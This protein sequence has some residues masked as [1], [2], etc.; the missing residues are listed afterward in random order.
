[1]NEH[2]NSKVPQIRFKGFSGEWVEKKPGELCDL[3]T[4]GDWIESK[5]QSAS[6]IRLLQTGNVGVNEFID[7]ADKARWISLDTFERLKCEEVFPGDILISRLPEP[8]GR[9]CIVPKL[10]HRVITAVDCT[11]VRTAKSCDPAFLVQHLSLDSYFETINNYL[12]GGTRQR[13]SRSALGEILIQI[14]KFEEQQKIGTYFRELDRLI[15]LHQRKHDKLVTLKKAML[16]KIFPQP[17]ATIPEIRFKGFS[18]GWMEIQLGNVCL[19][20][21]GKKDADEGAADGL[22]PFFTCADNHIYSHSFSFDTEAILIAGNANVGQTKYYQGKFEAYQRTYVLTDFSDINTRY[23]YTILDAKLQESLQKQVQVSAM[24]YIKLPMLNEFSLAV[25]PTIEEQKKI[26][27]Y[28]HTLDSL[29]SQHALQ[30]EKLKQI[31]S[32]CLEKMF[33]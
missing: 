18:G 8:A 17:G 31:K 1:M 16:Q 33:V 22:Y 5:D 20:R 3:F 29:I 6:G 19:I 4:D 10:S 7:K 2:T 23:L 21:T 27:T 25:P 26:G 32:A 9:A 30:L 14:P 11:I 24:S 12:G 15:G 28:F 13:I